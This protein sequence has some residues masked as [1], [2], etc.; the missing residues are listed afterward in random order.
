MEEMKK[1]NLLLAII[2]MIFVCTSWEIAW[3]SQMRSEV[4][5][6]ID[7]LHEGEIFSIQHTTRSLQKPKKF[8]PGSPKPF[9]AGR[10]QVVF[11]KRE[12]KYTL[13]F[14]TE[15]KVMHLAEVIPGKTD[16]AGY[17][18]IL[19]GDDV[20]SGVVHTTKGVTHTTWGGQKTEKSLANIKLN[21]SEMDY[22]VRVLYSKFNRKMTKEQADRINQV[23]DFALAI[24][25]S[26]KS[27][28]MGYHRSLVET[29][30]K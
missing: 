28:I 6:Y 24:M 18:K 12:E 27:G 7:N 3:S 29:L 17:I 16:V 13:L 2:T 23:K 9:N 4:K 19:D 30:D 5:N 8:I 10:F 25:F 26:N 14:E 15:E 1:P 22:L 11:V 21:Y 20:S